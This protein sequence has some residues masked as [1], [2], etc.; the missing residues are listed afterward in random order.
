MAGVNGNVATLP[1]TVSDSRQVMSNLG[2]D[3]RT[4]SRIPTAL[5]M[6]NL[7]QVQL[8]SFDWFR[9]EGLRELL[10]EISP[11]SDHHKK[12]ELSIFDPRFDPPWSRMPDGEEKDRAKI[13]PRVCEVWCRERDMTYA[14][15]LRVSAR[16]IMHDT[17]EIKETGPDGIRRLPDDDDRW[18]V[19]HQRRGASRRI[20]AGP[21]PGVHFE[22]LT[23]Q[24]SGKLLTSAKLI[25]RTGGLAR[26]RNLESRC[27]LGEGRPQGNARV[28]SAPAI[29]YESNEELLELFAGV[30]T[31]EERR[32]I[33]STLEK[34]Q[35]KSKDEALIELYRRLRPGDPPTRENAVQMLENLFFNER[36]YDLAL[37]WAATN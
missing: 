6:P 21:S 9:R 8:E 33:Q 22:R 31:N 14:A 37:E 36:R 25:P 18:H 24:Q 20:A 4:Y 28:D 35:T 34:E 19:H 32:Y 15:P 5:E 29:G 3:R 30:D 17:G 26:I 11:I 1:P 13:D 23:D 16:L 7:V 27:P 2:V 12:M 10:E